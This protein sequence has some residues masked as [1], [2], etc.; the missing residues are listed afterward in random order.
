MTVALCA[1]VQA[2]RAGFQEL[3]GHLKESF[4]EEWLLRRTH[5]VKDV[6]SWHGPTLRKYGH[7]LVLSTGR[8]GQGKAAVLPSGA[9]ERCAS[10]RHVWYRATRVPCPT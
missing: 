7:F 8:S 9:C 4:G 2:F 10:G 1:R 3:A 5:E 6:L